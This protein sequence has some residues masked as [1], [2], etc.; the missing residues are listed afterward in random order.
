LLASYFA[1]SFIL[2]QIK[3]QNPLCKDCN[4]V[5]ISLDTL[6]AKHLPCYGYPRNTAPNL[7]KFAQENIRFANA[8]SNSFWTLPSSVSEFTGLYPETHK[9]I[10]YNDVLN[11]NTPFLPQ[12]LQKNGYTTLFGVPLENPAIPVKNALNRGIDKYLNEYPWKNLFEEF[13]ENVKAGKKTFLY[14]NDYSVHA[15]YLTEDRPKIYTSD[16]VPEIPHTFGDVLANPSE[17]FFEYL[18]VQIPQDIKSGRTE[19]GK[20]KEFLEFIDR[21]K[22]NYPALK[23][24]YQEV[25][26]TDLAT[27][28]SS[29]IQWF[30]WNQKIDVNNKRHIEYIKAL[31]DQ[32]IHELDESAIEALIS[33]IN[34]ESLKNNTILII[35][36]EHGEEFA[37]H[38]EITHITIYNSNIRIPFIMY[39]PDMK[40]VVVSDSVQLTDLPPT[41]LDIVGINEKYKFQG[42]SLVEVLKG[43]QLEDRQLIINGDGAKNK[44]IVWKNWKLILNS[45]KDTHK[46]LELYDISQDMEE[47]NNLLFSNF[48]IAEKMIN[49]YKLS[50][51]EWE[52]NHDLPD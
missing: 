28:L 51:E 43:N 30:N 18:S 10:T 5:W 46:P 2:R 6:S 24:Y 8:Y 39:I 50:L 21:N 22:N 49:D 19:S 14:V 38:G 45:E 36:A 23:Q 29:Y 44:A 31:Y 26:D 48:D 4:I 20:L 17:E 40:K 13:K 52:S 33:F 7:C 42:K 25:L 12:I 11:G 16:N 47:Q 35:S 37:E 15:P 27:S 41:I 3:K 34:D 9:V 1:G 32:R